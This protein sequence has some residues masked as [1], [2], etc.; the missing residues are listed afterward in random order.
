[1]SRRSILVFVGSVLCCLSV[2]VWA[3]PRRDPTALTTTPQVFFGEDVGIRVTGPLDRN[4]PVQ[5]TLVVKINGRWV[6]VMSAP[7]LI[8]AGK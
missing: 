5:G 6:D 4:G 1:M 3:Q 7:K 2:G 8:P